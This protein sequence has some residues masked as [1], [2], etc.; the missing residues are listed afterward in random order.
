MPRVAGSHPILAQLPKEWP[1]VL[2]LN[3]VQLRSDAGTQLL[4]EVSYR[5]RQFPLLAVRSFGQGR[6]LA[7]MTDI[8]PHWMSYQFLE[9]RTYRQLMQAMLYWLCR[10][11]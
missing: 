5:G 6:T 8:G 9:S 1:P 4:A 3:R 10:V 11:A 7:F 2:G